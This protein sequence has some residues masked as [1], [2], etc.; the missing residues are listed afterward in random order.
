MVVDQNEPA[1][2]MPSPCPCRNTETGILQLIASQYLAALIVGFVNSATVQP[3]LAL[4]RPVMYREMG[5][6]QLTH[7]WRD[8]C[9]SSICLHRSTSVIAPHWLFGAI[10]GRLGHP[11]QWLSPAQAVCPCIATPAWQRNRHH[12]HAALARTMIC[13][14]SGS[15]A[16]GLHQSAV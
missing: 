1:Q 9:T 11:L 2:Q 5:A 4:E 12:L 13:S 3:I 15:P 16:P 6:G 8:C 14:S 7:S 10:D